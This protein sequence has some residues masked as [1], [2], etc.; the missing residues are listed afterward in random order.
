MSDLVEKDNKQALLKNAIDKKAITE[1]HMRTRKGVILAGG[2]GT[3]L[4]PLTVTTSKQLLP[5]YDKP[6]IYYPL[7]VLMRCGVR[8]VLI[9]TN[10]GDERI[11]HKLFGDGSKLG[12]NISYTIQNKPNGIPE[13][14]IL[15]ERFIGND[16]VV[17]IL[18]DNIFFGSIGHQLYL[19][20]GLPISSVFVHKVKDPSAYGVYDRKNK[21]IIEKPKDYISPWAVTGLYFYENDVIEIAKTLKPSARGELEITDVNE[22]YLSQEKLGVQ[23]LP[24]DVVWLD[25][26]THESLADATALVRTVEARQASKIGC[27]EEIAY[28]N[29]WIDSDGLAK[30]ADQIKG[31][32]GEY[33][34]NI[35]D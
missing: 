4:H 3:R 33:L 16:P 14:F 1:H 27:I 28:K 30:V 19:G 8:D 6:M 17:L 26:G 31:P 10:R 15:G 12:M 13:A 20:L 21:R 23:Y 11:F 18:G 2:H 32:Y 34:K 29:K 35:I 9:I 22:A 25:A 7:S 24:D 5:V